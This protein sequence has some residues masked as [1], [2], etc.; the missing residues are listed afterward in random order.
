LNADVVNN[1]LE[2]IEAFK[3]PEY[4]LVLMDVQMPKMNGM[5]AQRGFEK[6]RLPLQVTSL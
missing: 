5:E 4:D 6:L 2:A 1:G 3:S